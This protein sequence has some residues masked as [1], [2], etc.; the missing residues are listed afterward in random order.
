LLHRRD[1]DVPERNRAGVGLQADEAWRVGPAWEAAAG[2]GIVELGDLGAVELH[3]VGLAL[4][5]DLEG[6]PLADREC[7]LQVEG[8]V[9]FAVDGAGAVLVGAVG[10]PVSS[11]WTSK[12]K[13][14]AT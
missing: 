4:D 12:P 9:W 11:I 7:R 1:L 8:L 5:A 6:V 2:V 3:G 13:W 10:A 14:T